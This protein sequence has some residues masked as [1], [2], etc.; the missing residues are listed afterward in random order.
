MPF[1]MAFLLIG[2]ASFGSGLWMMYVKGEAFHEANKAYL[3]LGHRILAVG[4]ALFAARHQ[5]ER[6]RIFDASGKPGGQLWSAALVA[7]VVTL[8]FLYAI[9]FGFAYF[10]RG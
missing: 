1:L 8:S 4:L 9:S 6:W 2:L 10:L 5:K 7:L 3:R